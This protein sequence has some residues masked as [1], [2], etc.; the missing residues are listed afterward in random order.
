MNSVHA[1]PIQKMTEQVPGG[2]RHLEIDERAVAIKS[3]I[4]RPEAIHV[5]GSCHLSYEPSIA[6]G[7]W[8]NVPKCMGIRQRAS[9]VTA[10]PA[11]TFAVL[12]LSRRRP[13]RRLPCIRVKLP[14]RGERSRSRTPPHTKRGAVRRRFSA[15]M[16]GAGASD[17]PDA[18]GSVTCLV[19]SQARHS[20]AFEQCRWSRGTGKVPG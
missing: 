16:S 10:K 1:R 13:E 17:I 2:F 15:G 9:P 7:A 11:Q 14:K 6:A 12:F 5:F 18:V 4:F 20:P 19:L 3:H 8:Q